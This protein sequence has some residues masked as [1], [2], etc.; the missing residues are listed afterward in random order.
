MDTIFALASAPG[1]A[2]VAVVRVSG[3]N[4]FDAAQQLAG[5][6]PTPRFAALCALKDSAGQHL[7]Q[8]LLLCFEA[9]ASFT[10]EPVVEFQ[11][12]GSVAVVQAVM[13]ELGGLAG[14]RLAEPGE[15]TRR[16]LE[17]GQMDLTQVEALS[18][19][20]DS[21]TESQRKH[22]LTVLEGAL[23]QQVSDWRQKLIRAA[24]LLEATIDFADEEVP[25]DVSD[26][27]IAL[28]A[29]VS[30]QVERELSGLNATERMKS[31][32]EVAIVGPPNS[33][34]ST[35]LNFLAGRDAAITSEIAGTTRD[36]IE[37][38][39]DI[40]GYSVTL[41]DTA[42]LRD[43]DDQVE[44][45]GIERAKQ[46][47][48]ASDIRVHLVP[49]GDQPILTPKDGDV[50]ARAKQDEDLGAF[51]VSGKTGFGVSNLIEK[52]KA[53]LDET[54]GDLS[55][56]SRERHRISLVS[57]LA[58]LIEAQRI[59][60]FGPDMYDICSEEIRSCIRGFESLL[61]H[62]DVEHLLDEIFSSFCVGK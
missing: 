47:A 25:V 52:I 30:A 32:F 28:L 44:A 41:L 23:G 31:G 10:G 17:N 50:V 2:G 40:G 7:D 22:A 13:R 53:T 19:L 60:S 5:R 45:I 29:E 34:K 58:H 27:V 33:G 56:V 61:G 43:T 3:P 21:E 62:V 48:A 18:D 15:F 16:A 24:A 51:G 8:A 12:H 1:K 39:M 9:G 4:A 37:V 46:R 14:F 6:I 26:E 49:E 54:A 59:L 36:V 38:R 11:L 55:L 35:L 57:G 20:I 42:G